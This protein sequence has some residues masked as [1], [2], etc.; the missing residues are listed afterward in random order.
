MHVA[1]GEH[2]ARLPNGEEDPSALAV[3]VI[4]EVAAVS[5]SEAVR[6][7]LAGGRD[8]DDADHRARRECHPLV[9]AD[10]TVANLEAP[11]QGRCY[12]IDQ[13]AEVRDQRGDA[14]LDRP[15]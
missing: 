6:E 15:D 2:P 3:Q 4:V 11:G 12:V 14:P 10:L 7:R 5:A 8:A 9:H 1:D 13:L